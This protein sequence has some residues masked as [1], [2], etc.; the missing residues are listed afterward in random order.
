M[1]GVAKAGGVDRLSGA[2]ATL[3]PMVRAYLEQRVFE[4]P[5]ELDDKVILPRLAQNDAQAPRRRRI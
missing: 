4:R 5:V 3:A 1:R 2:F